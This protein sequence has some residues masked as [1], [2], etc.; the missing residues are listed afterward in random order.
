M[1]VTIC[2]V[3]LQEIFIFSNTYPKHRT[4][5]DEKAPYLYNHFPYIEV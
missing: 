5:L 4:A 2:T 3:T 1:V